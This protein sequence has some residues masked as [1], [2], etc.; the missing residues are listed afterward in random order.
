MYESQATVVEQ[1]MFGTAT[2]K[3]FDL[4]REEVHVELLSNE[5]VSRRRPEAML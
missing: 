3:G 5:K 1:I 2:H 4:S